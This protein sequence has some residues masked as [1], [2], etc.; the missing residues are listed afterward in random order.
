M[1]AFSIHAEE[2]EQDKTEVLVHYDNLIYRVLEDENDNIIPVELV[3]P[4]NYDRPA[5]ELPLNCV[6]P[7][8]FTVEDKTYR[9]EGIDTNA[10]MDIRVDNL[11]IPN[12]V[13][14]IKSNALF[15]AQI[16]Q[17]LKY[18]DEIPADACRGS[19]YV[20]VN[21]FT[22]PSG[23]VNVPFLGWNW[24]VE[25]LTLPDS[26]E[27]L[28]STTIEGDNVTLLCGCLN[29]FFRNVYIGKGLRTIEDE[30]LYHATLLSIYMQPTIPPECIG[31]VFGS[32]EAQY[33]PRLYIPEESYEIYM[34]V[35]P[36]NRFYVIPRKNLAG[37]EDASLATF[38]VTGGKGCIS[39]SGCEDTNMEVFDM[40]G[41]T[42]FSGAA[43]TVDGLVKGI[44]IVKS[45][46]SAAKVIVR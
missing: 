11:E 28:C 32:I 9:L 22:I 27:R 17:E 29:G 3:N 41:R 4:R 35:E 43:T 6:L 16:N 10:L 14:Y 42:V 45:G 46:T 21:K 38:G 39:V 12:S 26:V 44:Y 8:T 31:N 2:P 33:I 37:V 25:H 20:K 30:A 23:W 7:A 24:E 13:N 36:W 5:Y 15:C 19:N 1:G 18:P 40:N 34:A